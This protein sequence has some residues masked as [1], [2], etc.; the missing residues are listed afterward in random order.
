VID[1]GVRPLRSAV[2]A[3]TRKTSRHRN[4]CRGLACRFGSVVTG[5]AGSWRHARMVEFGRRRP[6]RGAVTA[7]AGGPSRYVPL[8]FA[9]G[10]GPVVA[11]RAGPC[12]NIR[13]GEFCAGECLSGV[14]G[15]AGSCGR[16]VLLGHHC[17]VLGE[18]RAAYMAT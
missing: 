12:L 1:L 14:A 4:V 15:V 7:V 8:R 10:L 2:A 5:F 16:D 18:S 17:V 13:V 9:R 3:V 11:G 6:R